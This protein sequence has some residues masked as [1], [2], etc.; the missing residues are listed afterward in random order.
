MANGDRSHQDVDQTDRAYRRRD[1]PGLGGDEATDDALPRY[2][3]LFEQSHD[4]ILFIALDGRIVD[5]NPAA[6]AAYGYDRDTLTAMRI[7]DLRDP[8]TVADVSEQIRRANTEGILFETRHRRRDGTTFPVEVSSLGADFGGERLLLSII[9]D[10][11]DRKHAEE[12]RAWLSA[13]VESSRD[14]IVSFDHEARVMSWNRAAVEMF[15]YTFAEVAG[16]TIAETVPSFVPPALVD[17]P[18]DYFRRVLGGETVSEMETVRIRKDGTPIEIA[19]SAYPIRNARGEVIGVGTDVRDISARKQADA[20]R[21]RLHAERDALLDSAAEGIFG[22][23]A[24]G[25]LTFINPAAV[26]MLGFAPDE[27]LGR[28]MHGLIHHS[29]PDGSPYPKEECP[30]NTAFEYGRSLHLV[31][32]VLWRKDGTSFPALYSVSSVVEN[33]AVTAGVVTIVDITERKRAE[34]EVRAS[35][36]R[37]RAIFEQAGA[38]IAQVGLDGRWLRVNQRLCEIT[39]Y[40]E[41]ELLARTFQDITPR[42][43][44]ERDLVALRRLLR[45][46]I[47]SYSVEKRYLCKEGSPVWVDLT[48]SL[49]HTASGAPDYFVSVVEDISARKRA[50]ERLRLLREASDSLAAS[51]D[52][53][54][55]L[56]AAASLLVPRLVDWCS[57]FLREPNGGIRRIEA[58]YDDP[59]KRD[60]AHE[61]QRYTATSPRTAAVG[62]GAVLR[63]GQPQL[64]PEVPDGFWQAIAQDPGHLATLRRLGFVSLIFVPLRARGQ[65]LG[66]VALATA[67]SER[68]LD[69]DD[70]TFA[71]SFAER[72]AMAID[73]ARLIREAQ[74]AEARYRGLFN[75]AA[76]SI[77]AYGAD[78]NL[79]EANEAVVRLLGYDRAELK[80]LGVGG[81]TLLTDPSIL[82]QIAENL[83]RRGSWSGEVDVR[84]KDGA[85]VPVDAHVTRID[86]PEGPVYLALWHDISERKARER[87]EHEF[88]A[89][90]AHDLKNPLTAVRVQAQVMARRLRAGR[91]DEDVADAGLTAIEANTERMAR[92]IDELGDVAQLRLGRTLE[93]RPESTDL[94]GL[95]KHLAATWQHT[96]ERHEIRVVAEVPTLVGAWDPTRLERV[97]ENLLSN[98]VKYSPRGGPIELRVCREDGPE[99]GW[100]TVSVRDEGIGV[101]A[102]DLPWIF[103][104]Y[105]RAGNVAGRLPGTGIGLAGARQIVEQH[106][107]SIAI[108]SDEGQG[109]TVTVRLPRTG[110]G[111]G[112]R[113][114]EQ[115]TFPRTANPEPRTPN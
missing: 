22:M 69:A 38:G 3:L 55:T 34:E 93:L 48:V 70:L 100:A 67:E 44:L 103:E 56:A 68:R 24:H 31:E 39:G 42:E 17:Q 89:D 14:A 98:A 61:V 11:S 40:T 72:A 110:S 30:I 107:G 63:T 53:E 84:R 65:T 87:F 59:A 92:R 37:F 8:A 5:A 2:R 80:A 9:R 18:L 46:Q 111:F 50:E 12:T 29:R 66:V 88:L 91:L 52:Y 96:A 90:V 99:G 85:L 62:V 82:P 10:I 95:A 58:E 6:L 76:E 60:L 32:E 77:V 35:E 112:D 16:R 28:D 25:D 97:L 108:A 105:R 109:T 74:A 104:R 27:V 86:L 19:I 102:A 73:N 115:E 45:G 75:G 57:I 49:V 54:E 33:G 51:I 81:T 71:E 83:E 78:G 43:D 36:A 20:A 47:A 21:E 41:T 64:Y 7:A 101:P 1:A 113:G 26:K 106:G 23:D 4:V 13:S 79:L 94:V 114:S 15:G